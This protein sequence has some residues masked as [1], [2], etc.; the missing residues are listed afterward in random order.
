VQ[1]DGE[2]QG[3]DYDDGRGAGAGGAEEMGEEFWLWNLDIACS[4][5]SV[6]Q[7]RSTSVVTPSNWRNIS[8]H[9][10]VEVGFTN[11]SLPK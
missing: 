7:L 10:S 6:A 11:A 2:D 3:E 9:C 8:R 4:Q 1:R 5:C